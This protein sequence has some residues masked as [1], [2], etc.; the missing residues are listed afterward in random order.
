M[1]RIIK[2]PK[3]RTFCAVMIEPRNVKTRKKIRYDIDERSPNRYAQQ[4]SP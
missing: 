3:S 4:R 2:S 1:P